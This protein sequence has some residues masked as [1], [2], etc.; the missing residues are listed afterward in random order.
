MWGCVRSPASCLPGGP[1]DQHLPSPGPWGRARLRQAH[2]RPVNAGP[3]PTQPFPS[4][5]TQSPS[6]VAVTNRGY[7]AARSER[8]SRAS[9]L[10]RALLFPFEINRAPSF[11]FG[12]PLDTPSAARSE[13]RVAP[14]PAAV[15]DAGRVP[16]R[17]PPPVCLRLRGALAG[18]SPWGLR[19]RLA[20]PVR[21][22]EH[23]SPPRCLRVSVSVS[24]Q[25]PSPCLAGLAAG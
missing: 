18:G 10:I 8:A 1:Q 12:T 17:S 23:P 19:L 15:G 4:R 20:G 3:S 16:L 2:P 21:V 7:G 6:R 13:G 24:V 25:S 22:Y 14:R 9:A 11:Q 5:G